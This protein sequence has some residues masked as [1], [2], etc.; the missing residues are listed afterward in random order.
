MTNLSLKYDSNDCLSIT[1][2]WGP[3]LF[4]ISTSFMN[5]LTFAPVV[6]PM[7]VWPYLYHDSDGSL[8]LTLPLSWPW[9]LFD[10]DFTSI[11]TLMA[12]WPWLY[13]N[14]D[15][16]GCLS[17]NLP[18]SWLRWLPVLVDSAWPWWRHRIGYCRRPGEP[19][20]SK[21][22]WNFILVLLLRINV[23]KNKCSYISLCKQTCKSHK[24]RYVNFNCSSEKQLF[25]FNEK[26]AL[27]TNC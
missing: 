20:G 24:K 5:R 21:L 8:T 11:M 1:E 27:Q 2:P 12:V 15:P 17:L 9:W 26:P 25:L 23:N 10:L 13:L 4:S 14:H 18:Q 6:I 7:T 3:C 16:D 22:N 19:V